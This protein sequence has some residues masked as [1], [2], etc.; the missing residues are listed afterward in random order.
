MTDS[1]SRSVG[2]DVGDH[3][4]K[5]QEVGQCKR[6]IGRASSGQF[7]YAVA[8]AFR[9]VRRR[10]LGVT[11]VDGGESRARAVLLAW[12]LQTREGRV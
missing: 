10:L 11:F 4:G 9:L 1:A 12:V 6:N 2:I 5:K 7:D 3:V 8:N